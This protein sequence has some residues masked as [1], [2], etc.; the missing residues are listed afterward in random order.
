[1]QAAGGLISMTGEPGRPGVRVGLVA[2]RPGNGHLGR[3]R[4]ARRAARA[5]LERR[6]VGGRRLALRD[7]AR[8]HRL[9]PRRLPRDRHRAARTGDPVPDGR[10]VPGVR[11]P[12]RGA[13]DRRRQRSHLRLD[14][15]RPRAARRSSTIRASRPTPI[16]CA[17]ATSSVRS[18]RR[19]SATNDTA[20]WQAR[21]TEAGVPAAPV[22]DVADVAQR[23]ANGSARN[24]AAPRPSND[25]RPH[26]H[27]AAAVVRR[28]AGAAPVGASRGRARTRPRCSA[29]RDTTQTRSRHSPQR[30]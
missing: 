24:A 10:A 14:L 2:D 19:R 25:P 28:R 13:D 30:E 11:D 20:Y 18:W 8:L 7:R 3:D 6:G 1:M 22:A 12:R 29:R 15:R 26:A 21:L 5:R 4:R 27:R 9:P 23:T 17:T 16:V